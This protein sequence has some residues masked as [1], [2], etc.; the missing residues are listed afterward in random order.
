[1]NIRSA[2]WWRFC[3]LLLSWAGPASQALPPGSASGGTS[4][5]PRFDLDADGRADLVVVSTR[6][7]DPQ[8][9]RQL[10]LGTGHAFRVACAGNRDQDC[11]LDS[12]EQYVEDPDTRL[13]TGDFN[14]DRKSDL[15]VISANPAHPRRMLL[16]SNGTTLV[17]ACGGD[18]TADCGLPNDP[19]LTHP[20]TRW[21]TGDYDGD[22]RTDLLMISA[23]PARPRR[24][25]LLAT[26]HGFETVCGGQPRT[27]C[28]FDPDPYLTSPRTQTLGGDYDGD[29]R[30]DVLVVSGDRAAPWR[31]LLLSTGHA[32]RSAC[33]SDQPEGC[34]L[35]VRDYMFAFETR[36]ITGDFNGD[37]RTDLFVVSGDPREPRRKLLVSTGTGFG[38]NRVLG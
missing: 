14:G 12:P 17:N 5:L 38:I 7:Q 15:L 22:R 28:G 30:S 35:D 10:L 21:L 33:A 32:F 19:Y 16:V 34:G 23:D 8:P 31:K 4:N 29:G 18:K 24:L 1:M 25:L 26:G 11:G 37:D 9:M 2:D 13:L 36:L 27:P 20:L 3:L 6:Q